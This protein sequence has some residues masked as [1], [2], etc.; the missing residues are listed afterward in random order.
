M[1]KLTRLMSGLGIA[2]SLCLAP[3]MAQG[4]LTEFKLAILSPY[5]GPAAQT[6]TEVKNGVT[7]A[8]DEV[9]WTV[10]KYKIVPVW[11]D[12]QSDPAKAANA[13]EQAIVQQHVQ[14]GLMNWH[15]SVAVAVME[16]TAKYKIPH[17]LGTGSTELI[18]EKFHSNVDKYGYW[19]LKSW[20]IPYKLSGA[21]VEA[22]E[23]AIKAGTYKP[24]DKTVVLYAEDTD[25]GRSFSN[26][27]A[28]EF[29]KAGWKV[30]DQE[31][32]PMGQTEFYP[33]LNKFKA[34]H[35]AV[36]CG[37]GTAEPAVTAFVKQA[38]EVGLEGILI[39][40]ALGYFGDWYKLCGRASDYVLDEIPSWGSAKGKAFAT[41]YKAKFNIPPSPATTG[42]GYD[43]A[44]FFIKLC[45]DIQA[46]GQPLTS[47][48]IYQF[49]KANV[50]TGKWTFKDGIVM[51]EY[52]FTPETTPDPVMGPNEYIFPVIQYKGGV[53]K[54]IFPT[55]WAESKLTTKP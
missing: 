31:Y 27:S 43:S 15:S 8:F 34:M 18:N 17:M 44:K 39:A 21:Y 1:G 22:L 36:I 24:K 11:I 25:F 49:V 26:G 23:A 41:A 54:I 50:W 55:E 12:S 19:M 2:A 47:D 46:K 37:S 51:K 16:I 40:D 9:N 6:G 10:G 38:D 30:L 35:P 20:P 48:T 4:N 7:W 28:A 13:Y 3:A 33:L 29:R 42:I 45:K 52:K 5:S 53:G 32:F 14:A